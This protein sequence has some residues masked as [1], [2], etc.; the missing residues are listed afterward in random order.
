M[1]CLLTGDNFGGAEY[2]D[3]RDSRTVLPLNVD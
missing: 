1:L 3:R 2:A